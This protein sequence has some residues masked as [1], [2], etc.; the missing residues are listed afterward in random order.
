MSLFKKGK[1]QSSKIGCEVI[2]Q[3]AP[4]PTE[5]LQEWKGVV[6][7]IL[8]NACAAISHTVWMKIKQFLSLGFCF[9]SRADVKVQRKI[10]QVLQ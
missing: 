8:G 7:C 5:V 9:I 3:D 10:D 1:G 2:H 6:S 4:L